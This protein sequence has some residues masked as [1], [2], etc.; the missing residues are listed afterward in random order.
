MGQKCK[1]CQSPEINK[2]NELLL[3]GTSY[4]DIAGQFK[5]AKSSVERHA[6]N[7][8]PKTLIKSKEVKEEVEAD[9]LF[10][11]IKDLETKTLAILEKAETKGELRTCLLAIREA[12]ENVNLLAKLQGELQE[13]VVINLWQSQEWQRI[14]GTIL[15]ELE[16]YPEVK[17]RIKG[18]L[19]RLEI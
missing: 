9:N 1:V 11:K 19:K 5:L 8:L 14:L 13:G 6:K 18:K 7:H 10:N 12:R 2:I 15:S 16:D 3:N 4:R 17:L